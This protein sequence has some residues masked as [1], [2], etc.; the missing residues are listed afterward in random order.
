MALAGVENVEALGP[1]PRQR[2]LDRLDRRAGQRQVVAHLVD[3]A[4][5]PA[6]VGLHVDD[7]ERGILRTKVAVV[8]PG[9]GIGGD[10]AFRVTFFACQLGHGSPRNRQLRRR[11]DQRALR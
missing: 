3:I 4:A 2:A 1:H 5:D 10:V 9:I 11:T 8:G 6:E 7:D